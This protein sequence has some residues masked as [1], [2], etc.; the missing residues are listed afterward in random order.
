LFLIGPPDLEQGARFGGRTGYRHAGTNTGNGL[1][2]RF[3][4][5]RSIFTVSNRSRAEV[6]IECMSASCS[7]FAAV[8]SR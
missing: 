3:R 1:D 8:R 4:G 6:Q 5:P 7:A 2:C